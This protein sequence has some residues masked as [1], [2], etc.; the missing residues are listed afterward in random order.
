MSVGERAS[1]DNAQDFLAPDSEF[2]AGSSPDFAAHLVDDLLIKYIAQFQLDAEILDESEALQILDGDHFPQYIPKELVFGGEREEDEGAGALR[3]RVV[4][5]AVDT[6]SHTFKDR[7]G[8]KTKTDSLKI[9][10]R[11]SESW[12]RLLA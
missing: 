4:D 1:L 11:T 10:L 5:T 3:F 8:V 2:A 7:E 12:E 9:V 6:V